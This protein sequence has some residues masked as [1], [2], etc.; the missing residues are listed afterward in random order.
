MST[1]VAEIKLFAGNFIPEGWL[2]CQGQ[3]L[4]MSQYPALASLLGSQY[5]GNGTTT[6]GLPDYS[7]RTLIGE[8]NGKGL[9]PRVLGQQGGIETVTL[10][11]SEIPAHNH[12]I[13]NT[14][15]VQ[16][17]LTV[18]ATGVVKCASTAGNSADPNNAF[19]AK[20]KAITGDSIYTTD[21]SQATA[22]M[23]PK[24]VDINAALQG[25]I[26]VEVSSQC[27]LTGAGLAHE[28]MQPWACA[29]YIIN[30]DG[31][32]PNRT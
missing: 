25:N 30:W 6:F 21:A 27:G 24:A 31:V 5:G 7:G 15:A 29:S 3:I 22:S 8:G 32:Y 13:N 12:V 9:S 1:F 26:A 14:P 10:Q 11:T 16:N 2:A 20:T 23:N 28:N 17:N 18:S 4:A 19:L